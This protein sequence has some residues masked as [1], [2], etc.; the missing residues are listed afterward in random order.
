MQTIAVEEVSKVSS[1]PEAPDNNWIDEFV[2][3]N[4]RKSVIDTVKWE[5]R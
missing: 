1:L 3:R 4:Y 5:A 2:Y